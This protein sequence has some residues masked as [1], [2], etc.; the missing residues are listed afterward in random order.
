MLR[1][2]LAALIFLSSMTSAISVAAPP[3]A[4][5]SL[6]YYEIGG[7]QAI[8]RPPNPRITSTRVSGAAELGLGYSCGKFDPVVAV[9]HLLNNVKDG[10]ENMMNAM[11]LAAQ[12]SIAS[13]PALILQRA[14]PGLYDLFQ[15]ALLK[16][17]ATVNLATKSCE[18]MEAEIAQGKNPFK[19]W[20]VLSKGNDWQAS[21]GIETDILEA[22]RQ[23]ESRNGANGI[24][25]L[26]G[27]K[28]GAAQD[29]IQIIGDTIRAGYNITLNRPATSTA[30][31]SGGETETPLAAA[32]ASPAEAWD[33]AVTVLGDITV[34]TC[35]GCEPSGT[36]GAGLLPEHERLTGTVTTSLADLVD[37]STPPTLDNLAPVSAPGIR[38]TRQIVEALQEMPPTE[39]RLTLEKL[40]GE[41]A[42]ARVLDKSLLTRRLLLAGRQVP[43]IAAVGAAQDEI[44][45][46]LA[47]LD[48]EIENLLFETR[49][50]R[51]VVSTT[52]AMI[53]RQESLRRREAL[54]APSLPGIRNP[55]PLKGGAVSTPD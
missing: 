14:N 39:Q 21:M 12:S 47:E 53:L 10:T 27:R 37:G 43:E 25:W 30:P 16:A 36:P 42:L 45:R 52:A 46:K 35:D 11:V 7:A 8:S 4:G 41:I 6:W 22:K 32:W 29:P 50:R 40:A 33:W 26:G 9:T 2:T 17:E 38:I 34:R 18:Q 54:V 13:L 51:E 28:G 24:P 48:Q 1:K 19:E 20:V 49:V 5:D 23:V 3:P 31:V 55:Y 44:D 15:N